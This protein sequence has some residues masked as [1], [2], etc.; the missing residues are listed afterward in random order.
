MSDVRM[1]WDGD[2][3]QASVRA[4]GVKGLRDGSEHLLA[5]S[6]KTIPIET[7]EMM[8]SGVSDVDEQALEATVSYDTPY[9]VVQH[10]RTDLRHDPGRR[11]KW[12]ELTLDEQRARIQ[13]Y[14]ED[15]I[16]KALRG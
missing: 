5:E 12:L 13:R 9:T 6:N 3:V 10:E 8:R 4:A 11:A 2:K 1:R 7:A 14:I 15:E 16:K